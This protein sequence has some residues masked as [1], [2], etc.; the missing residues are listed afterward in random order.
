MGSKTQ[1]A[2]SY[3][4][5]SITL[6]EHTNRGLARVCVCVCVCVTQG[7]VGPEQ[8]DRPGAFERGAKD[9]LEISGVDVGQITKIVVSCQPKGNRPLWHLDHITVRLGD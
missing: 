8:L 2:Y 6:T 3:V 5:V 9:R 4:C 7:R 1:P